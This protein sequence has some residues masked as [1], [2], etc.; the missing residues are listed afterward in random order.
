MS[1]LYKKDGL[2]RE[3]RIENIRV[4]G[5]MKLIDDQLHSM[6]LKAGYLSDFVT[7]YNN[8][9]RKDGTFKHLIGN[10]LFLIITGIKKMD[11]K[12]EEDSFLLLLNNNYYSP[13]EKEEKLIEYLVRFIRL[14][15]TWLKSTAYL[16]INDYKLSLRHDLNNQIIVN[17]RKSVSILY[18]YA[19]EKF[20][21]LQLP[22]L[23]PVWKYEK[24]PDEV[25]RPDRF[26]KSVFYKFINSVQ[27]LKRNIELY[28]QEIYSS[29][30]NDPMIAVL[31]AFLQ[32]HGNLIG[33]FNQRW[34]EYGRFYLQQILKATP[35]KAIPDF[36]CLKIKMT[37]DLDFLE[38]P[39]G[40]VFQTADNIK[41]QTRD[42]LT[43]NRVALRRVVAL[44]GEKDP[45]IE[46]AAGFDYITGIRKIDF[47]GMIDAPVLS[48]NIQPFFE[49]K[50]RK[51][52]GNISAD[53]SYSSIGL[54]IRSWSLLLRE[55]TRLVTL[56]L[57]PTPETVTRFRELV[58]QVH[59]KWDKPEKEVVY[60]LLNEIFYVEIT[61]I[62]GWKN[63]TSYTAVFEVD[64][65]K[66]VFEISFSLSAEFPAVCSLPGSGG[67]PPAVRLLLNRDAWLFAYSWLKDLDFNSV[68]IKSK[69]IGVNNVQ[70][71]SELGKI[72]TSMPFYPF[73][74]MPGRGAWLV[75]GNYE[76]ALKKI[77]SIDINLKWG[78]LPDDEY[79]FAG[80]YF[81]YDKGIDN[82]SFT[83]QPEMLRNRKW[84]P[85]DGDPS[86]FLFNTAIEDGIPHTEP[87][88][89]LLNET[90]FNGIRFNNSV[91]Q[92]VEEEDFRYNMF[93]ANGFFR[94]RLSNPDI[95][96]G[97]HQ[98]QKILSD[99]LMKN[100][101][102][103]KILQTPNPPFSPQAEYV[104]IDYEAEEEIIL[105]HTIKKC[106]GEIFHLHPFGETLINKKGSMKAFRAVPV[107]DGQANLLWGFDNV[108]GGE[109]I[110]LYVSLSPQQKE[111]DKNKFPDIVWY[112]G[113]G[114][115]WSPLP[116][117]HIV[118]DE[119]RRFVESGIIEV[120]FPPPLTDMQSSMNN[121]YWLRT[122]FVK[123]EENVSD[124]KGFYLHVA[125]AERVIG[126][127]NQ[128]VEELKP[129]P[130][131]QVIKS[132]NKIQGIA[133]VVQLT[134]SSGGR[135]AEND[136]MMRVRL[137]ER[138]SHRNRA[139]NALDFEKL[140]LEN[141]GAVRKVKCFPCT[142][143]KSNRQGVVTL[144]I[145]PESDGKSKA[146]MANCKLLIDIEEFL[147]DYTG[148]FTT[149][150]A[151]NPVYEYLQVRCKVIL[152]KARS[153]GYY[154]RLLGREINQYIAFWEK[155]SEAPVFGH[156]VSVIDLANF[157]RSREYVNRIKNFSV[158]HL[159]EKGESLYELVEKKE[160]EQQN[161]DDT[162]IRTTIRVM[163][164]NREIKLKELKPIRPSLNWG[165][166]LPMEK[167]L[168]VAEW[169]DQDETA[170]I[171]EL[172]IGN[173][174][175]IS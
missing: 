101:R 24:F 28:E 95:G 112:Y 162:D 116:Q 135:G 92:F 128:G 150:D 2:S 80:Y 125:G 21:Q 148:M 62:A 145:I 152:Q 161:T 30:Y 50:G 72:D 31:I 54:M 130:P 68:V 17:L 122:S 104:S 15:E 166:L 169:E 29:G 160:F 71:Y 75:L 124:I 133:E 84:V 151:I 78:N 87:R 105:G 10:S 164:N 20:G 18:N 106:N 1:E 108:S 59:E 43:V 27:F 60:K 100:A 138:I 143:S 136:L 25:S 98:Y 121:L 159:K 4:P 115:N 70:L 55:G 88:F 5:E 48:N 131:L 139:V 146:P 53:V 44:I 111:I 127:D 114:F 154:L 8:K 56:H 38:I 158:L 134:Q 12:T 96:F 97:H 26:L 91:E 16:E 51:N 66:P 45:E 173:T 36:T 168:L 42:A 6:L 156:S 22:A 13:R 85:A 86:C 170:G 155:N 67:C 47:S 144:A 52:T 93:A 120:V 35:K 69:V 82:C 163:L 90:R 107:I 61:T 132:E 49:Q 33:R 149:I 83:V 137:S 14:F 147:K 46:P 64:I 174:F 7:Y 41:F 142:D 103:K 73:G 74:V 39:A 3:Q 40:T 89:R 102:S 119:T 63:I 109:T 171:N 58:H 129:V 79:G 76:L 77:S 157:I 126:S 175:V 117:N 11:I 110:H 65:E 19:K 172:E 99:V 32:N 113:D 57:K 81:Q 165:I 140:V 141:F 9:N 118:K 34:E 123:H 23:S 167:H 94:L 37:G 153:E